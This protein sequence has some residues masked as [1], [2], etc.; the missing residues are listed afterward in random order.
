[1]IA[2]LYDNFKHWSSTGSVWLISD[3]HFGTDDETLLMSP[4][5]H[6]SLHPDQYV[7]ELN[8]VIHKSDTLICLGDCGDIE[9]IKKLKAG[10]KVLIKGNHDDKGDSYY[11]KNENV[12]FFIKSE[13]EKSYDIRKM[14]SEQYENC[15]INIIDGN[16]MNH[17]GYWI[18]TIDNNL[19]DEVYSG[20]LFISDKILLSHEPVNGLK[21]CTNIH[22][23][24]HCG[25][26]DYTD[27]Q[28]GRHLNIAAD[29]INWQPVNLGKLIKNGLVAGLPTIHRL[30]IDKAIERKKEDSNNNNC[31]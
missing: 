27:E 18:A 19:F 7:E 22:G 17:K 31:Y 16:H 24:V 25:V 10:H 28:G 2:S 11:L 30:V 5:Y 15:K 21:F 12:K 1:M 3:P 6:S 26:Y 29:V 13:Y 20:A 8:K 23:H 14:L 4:D 9:Y